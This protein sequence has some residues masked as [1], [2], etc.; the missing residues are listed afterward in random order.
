[1]SYPGQDG[2]DLD[3]RMQKTLRWIS[4]KLCVS[5]DKQLTLSEP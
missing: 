1:M 4:L 3:L 5:L 2:G